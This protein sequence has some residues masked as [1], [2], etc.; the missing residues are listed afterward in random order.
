VK[1]YGVL[2]K[3][4]KHPKLS[5]TLINFSGLVIVGTVVLNYS[6]NIMHWNFWGFLLAVLMFFMPI[7]LYSEIATWV[8][9]QLPDKSKA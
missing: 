7:Y 1:D 3:L 8:E 4:R 2:R 6:V 5:R 9:G